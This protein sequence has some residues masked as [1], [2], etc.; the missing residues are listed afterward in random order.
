M[1]DWVEGI[2]PSQA[3]K[4]NKPKP[5]GA[6]TREP[7]LEDNSFESAK[8]LLP[9][10]ALNQCENL[11][12]AADEMRAKASSMFFDDKGLMGLSCCHDNLLFFTNIKTPGEQQFYM[13]ALLETLFQHLP[14]H[15]LVGFLYDIAYKLPTGQ[16]KNTA[17]LAVKDALR[18][19][20]A[21][22][23]LWFQMRTLNDTIGNIDVDPVDLTFVEEELPQVMKQYEKAVVAMHKKM[24]QLGANRLWM[25]AYAISIQLQTKLQQR[26]FE[27]ERVK[28]HFHHNKADAKQTTHIQD[29]MNHWDS[30]IKD[31]QH[32]SNKKCDQMKELIN[33]NKSPQ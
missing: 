5:Q 10:S 7:E 13:F 16:S 33:A 21:V 8:I 20:Q 23:Q 4:S 17:K 19:S 1:A 14:V 12:A 27:L 18:T 25:N 2:R 15:F 32:S 29:A 22:A 11:F 6:E 30:H 26:K 28:Q 24:S 31:L 3:L 9:T